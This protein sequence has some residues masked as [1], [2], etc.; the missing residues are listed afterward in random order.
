MQYP[1]AIL[2]D[3]RSSCHPAHRWV[4]RRTTAILGFWVV[5]AAI[6]AFASPT[7][8]GKSIWTHNGSTLRWVSSGEDRWMYYLQPRPGL[9]AIGVQPGTLL[10][11]GQRIGNILSGTAYVFSE[12]CP[13]TPYRVEGV[14]YSETDVRLDG[15]LRSRVT[16]NSREPQITMRVMRAV[17][18][19]RDSNSGSLASLQ[20]RHD[21]LAALRRGAAYDIA[22]LVSFLRRVEP[23][24]RTGR[25]IST[26]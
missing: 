15:A 24:H 25:I 1:L 12:N 7:R 22:E 9:A 14:I 5:L 2:S 16:K 19:L 18:P 21:L 3:I 11:Q 8:G 6:I 17:V 23:E 20:Q 4:V 26:R 10:F 13:P